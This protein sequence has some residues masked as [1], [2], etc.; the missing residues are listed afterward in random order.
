VLPIPDPSPAGPSVA[1]PPPPAPSPPTEAPWTPVVLSPP[2]AEPRAENTRTGLL[3]SSI[4]FALLW[5]PFVGLV[6]G[7]LALIGLIYLFLGRRELSA[8]HHRW[9]LLG[10]GLFLA[11]LAATVIAI[12]VLVWLEF[13]VVPPPNLL[14]PPAMIG[15]GLAREL[16]LAAAVAAALGIVGLLSRVLLVYAL[17]GRSTRRLLWVAFAGGVVLAVLAVPL[18]ARILT[19]GA[20]AYGAFS[21]YSTTTDL[22]SVAQ[23]VPLLMFAWAYYRVRATL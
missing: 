3:W 10:T 22:L 17:A 18:T 11:G 4:G 19:A 7:L 6:G 16:L 2:A 15:P 12:G 5:I 1:G 9:V 20:A 21:A 13:Q 23:A 14:A 8:A